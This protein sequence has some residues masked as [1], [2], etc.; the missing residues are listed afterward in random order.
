MREELERIFRLLDLLHPRRDFRSAWAALRSGN[1]FIHGQALDLLDSALRP[2]MKRLLVPLVDPEVTEA[3][4]VRLAHR[5]VG[6]PLETPEEAVAALAGTGD[7]W[8][9]S[10][11][12]YAIGAQGLRSLEPQLRGLERGPRPA[13]ARDRAPGAGEARAG[14]PGG[15][16]GALSRAGRGSGG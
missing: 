14:S 11:A 13:A 10:C 16:T 9:R 15:L 3:Q 1:A 8:L 4:R 6:A 2:E 7:P 5:L 12:A